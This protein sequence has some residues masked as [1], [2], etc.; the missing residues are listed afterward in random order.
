MTYPL[1]II[2]DEFGIWLLGYVIEFWVVYSVHMGILSV[3]MWPWSTDEYVFLW[4]FITKVHLQLCGNVY[5]LPR[6]ATDVQSNYG[7]MNAFIE[8]PHQKNNN[9]QQQQHQ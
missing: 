1:N 9:N 3:T 4:V 6:L 7:T 5:S 8:I 2:F